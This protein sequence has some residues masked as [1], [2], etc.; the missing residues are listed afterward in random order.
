M[1]TEKKVEAKWLHPGAVL[2]NCIPKWGSA[3]GHE[4][5]TAEAYGCIHITDRGSVI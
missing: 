4:N 3:F 2:E 5:G 1:N